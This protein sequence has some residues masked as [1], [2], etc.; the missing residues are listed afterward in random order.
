MQI[1]HGDQCVVT[2]VGWG[3]AGRCAQFTALGKGR[4]RRQLQ[5]QKKA[6]DQVWKADVWGMGPV[7]VW[8]GTHLGRAMRAREPGCQRCAAPASD[9]AVGRWLVQ[10]MPDSPTP[11]THVSMKL[12]PIHSLR[13]STRPLSQAVGLGTSRH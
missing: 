10:A 7:C 12:T 3:L 8:G 4:G 13:I 5:I 9:G 6:V 1:A 11:H 2:G